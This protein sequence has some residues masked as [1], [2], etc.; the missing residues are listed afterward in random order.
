MSHKDEPK[1]VHTPGEL[2]L[3]PD[4]FKTGNF[5]VDGAAKGVIKAAN[6]F[7]GINHNGKSDIAEFGPFV[8]KAIPVLQALA[9]VVHPELFE[10]WLLSHDWVKDKEGCKAIIGQLLHIATDA[11]KL[12]PKA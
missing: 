2:Q 8:L 12:A 6:D 1:V 9:P 11:A 3:N 5:V 7:D 10:A 4:D